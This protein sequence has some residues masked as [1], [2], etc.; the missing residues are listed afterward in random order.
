MVEPS[1]PLKGAKQLASQDTFVSF[2]RNP[3]MPNGSAGQMPAFPADQISDKDA[4][5]IYHY[6]QAQGWK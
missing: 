5:D 6:I 4:G 2:I 3:T 1:L